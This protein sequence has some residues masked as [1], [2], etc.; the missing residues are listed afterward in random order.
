MPKTKESE[1][2]PE[3]RINAMVDGAKAERARNAVVGKG[4][5]D[6]EKQLAQRGQAEGKTGDAL[7]V[8]IYEGLGGRMD[9][10]QAAHNRSQEKIAALQKARMKK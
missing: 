9:D 6:V 5:G 8:Y 4:K 1:E 10:V 7:V 3:A 2:K